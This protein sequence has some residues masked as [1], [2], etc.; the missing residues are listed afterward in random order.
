MV[1]HGMVFHRQRG[2][3]VTNIFENCYAAASVAVYSDHSDYRFF[4]PV[5]ISVASLGFSN[6][7]LFSDVITTLPKALPDRVQ[8]TT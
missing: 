3:V 8:A 7:M 4:L 1:S 6:K 2:F 5:V